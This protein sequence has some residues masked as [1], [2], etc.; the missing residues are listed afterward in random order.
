M[1]QIKNKISNYLKLEPFGLSKPD[2]KKK[3]IEIIKLQIKHHIKNCKIYK[4]WYERNNFCDPSKIEQYEDVPYLPSTIFKKINLRSS[5]KINKII[6][7]SGSTGQNKS[8]INIDKSTSNFQ[9]ICLTNILANSIGKKRKPFFIVDIEPKETFNQSTIS[10]RYAG[11]SGYLMAATSKKYLLKM[12]KD[13]KIIFD[14]KNIDDFVTSLKKE[15]IILIGYTYMLWSYLLKNNKLNFKSL[16][17]HKDTKIIHFGGWKKLEHRKVSKK[18]FISKLKNLIDIKVSSILD[19]YGFSEQLGTI[20]ISE[21]YKD[22]NVSSYS[23]ILVRDPKT[24]KVVKDGETGFMQ[25]LS[26]IPLSYPGFSILNDDMGYISSRKINKNIEKI[27]FK[28][29]ARLDSLEARGCGD[30]LPSHY[31]I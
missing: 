21:G 28:V 31:Y 24:L 30:T 10:A 14:N 25:F 4:T 20:Y 11:M 26:I 9:K 1:Q 18:E 15:P 17:C 29:N 16:S 3:F 12:N 8:V 23:H 27:E 5:I 2:K 6:S 19:I 7:S 13:G 22:C